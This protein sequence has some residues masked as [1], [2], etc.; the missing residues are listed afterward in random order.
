[1]ISISTPLSKRVFVSY[2]DRLELLDGLKLLCLSF[3]HHCFTEQLEVFLPK[4]T[5]N[6]F[7]WSEQHLNQNIHLKEYNSEV[8]GWSIKPDVILKLFEEGYDEVI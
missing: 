2:E 6:I 5:D 3:R 1:M 7:Q 8:K 4:V